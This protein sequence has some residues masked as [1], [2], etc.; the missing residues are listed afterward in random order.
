MAEVA[1]QKQYYPALDGLRGFAIVL[2]LLY[3][4]FHFVNHFFFAWL[5]VD[6]F[7]VLSGYLITSILLNSLNSTHYLRNFYA[8]RVLRVFPL[9]YLCLLIF[10]VLFPLLGLYKKELQFYIDNQWWFWFY[11]QNWLLSFNFP[12][13]ANMLNHFWSLAVEEQFYLVWPFIILWLRDPRK[14]LLFMM[15]VIVL[16]LVGR[17]IVW[18]YKLPHFNYTTFYTF[19]R[20][21]GICI[22]CI[23]ALLHR[24]HLNFLRKN[25]AAIVIVLA[26]VNFGFYFLNQT[27]DFPYLAFVGY[28]TFAAMFGLLI[29]EAVTGDIKVINIIF[30]LPVLKFFGMISYGLYVFHWPVYVM[31]Q[32]GLNDFFLQKLDLTQNTSNLATSL[33]ATILAVGLSIISYYAY[34]MKFLKLKKNFNGVSRTYA[35]KPI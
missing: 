21:D 28:T 18:M 35:T 32:Q 23:I 22:G 7:F 24:I 11:L 17:S 19:T 27:G 25:T 1:H 16:L 31:T 15:G 9:Y 4:N 34:E 33:V 8:K 5:G 12:T 6:L 26:A 13:S 3:H 2:V 29:H 14:L 10:L 20:I 30:G